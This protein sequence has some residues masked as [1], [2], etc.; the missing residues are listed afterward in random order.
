[1]IKNQTFLLSSA[2][3]AKRTNFFDGRGKNLPKKIKLLILHV[4]STIFVFLVLEKSGLEANP[5]QR[6]FGQKIVCFVFSLLVQQS[7]HFVCTNDN[8]I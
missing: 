3:T 2:V 7:G 4:F 8:K 1:M 6:K 5:F